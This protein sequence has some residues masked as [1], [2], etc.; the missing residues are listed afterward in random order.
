MRLVLAVT[1]LFATVGVTKAE[2][3]CD[4]YVG[5]T[6]SYRAARVERAVELLEWIE[7]LDRKI[8]APSPRELDWLDREDVASASRSLAA[9]WSVPAR[10]KAAR[11]TIDALLIE[12]D[13]LANAVSSELSFMDEFASWTKVASLI[14]EPGWVESVSALREQNIGGLKREPSDRLEDDYVLC[15]WSGG[16][17][18][19]E[20]IQRYFDGTLYED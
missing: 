1:L 6:G 16:W 17:I 7:Q 10:Q 15:T 14:I 8:S 2:S 5:F 11:E 19:Q 13:R 9:S 3:I 12:I 18:I 20:I 4:P